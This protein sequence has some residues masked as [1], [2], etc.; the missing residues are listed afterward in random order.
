MGAV[1]RCKR[2]AQVLVVH[3]QADFAFSVYLRLII[4]IREFTLYQKSSTSQS[5]L[6]EEDASLNS[7]LN[8][9]D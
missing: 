5:D 4:S 3:V 9:I 6:N 8:L 2:C 1:A 7:R